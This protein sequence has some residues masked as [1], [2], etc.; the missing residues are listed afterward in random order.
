MEV[1]SAGTEPPPAD[2]PLPLE[3][4]SPEDSAATSGLL[5]VADLVSVFAKVLKVKP[6]AYQDLLGLVGDEPASQTATEALWE[7]YQGLLRLTLSVSSC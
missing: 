4:L 1:V 7:L 3:W 6:A 2:V 5:Y